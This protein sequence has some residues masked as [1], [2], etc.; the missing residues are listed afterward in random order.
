MNLY[1]GYFASEENVAGD[2]PPIGLILTRHKDELLVEY[3]TYEMNSQ[4]FVQ[5][6]QLYL[7]DRDELRRQLEM[8]LLRAE[9]QAEREAGQDEH[10]AEAEL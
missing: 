1:L 6:Y 2:N 4:L 3:A 8:T 9:Q 7:P 10:A 5:K